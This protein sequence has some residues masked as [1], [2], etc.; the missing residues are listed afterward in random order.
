MRQPQR[1]ASG[2][3]K[4][5]TERLKHHNAKILR[6]GCQGERGRGGQMA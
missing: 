6:Q 5:K 2:K 4:R 3:I 1:G